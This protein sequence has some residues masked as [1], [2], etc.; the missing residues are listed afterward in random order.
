MRS[1]FIH[2]LSFLGFGAV[3]AVTAI[4]AGFS[5]GLV[6]AVCLVAYGLLMKKRWAA[7]QAQDEELS[8]CEQALWI[9]L[10][11]Y[12]LLL[13]HLI[14]G[15]LHTD[16]DMRIGQGS[17]LA[18]DSWMMVLA[19]LTSEYLFKNDTRIIDE[20][21]HK[22][23]SKAVIWG[24]RSLVLQAV[25][26]AFFL[27]LTPPVARS[28]FSHFLIANALIA[29][30]LSSYCTYISVRLFAYYQDRKLIHA[31]GNGK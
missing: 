22:Y 20:R 3:I 17:S 5:T 19:A 25:L 21:D 13:G 27:T 9:Q 29:F 28:L 1:L 2:I 6:G 24:Y 7:K 26:F 10:A 23:S 18:I 16:I 30:C 14:T 12:A 11:A 31:I 4:Q 15:L 8:H